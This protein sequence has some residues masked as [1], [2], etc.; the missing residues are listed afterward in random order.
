[1]AKAGFVDPVKVIRAAVTDAASVSSLTSIE[2]VITGLAKDDA[3]ALSPGG[4]GGMHYRRALA[5]MLH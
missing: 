3:L 5:E 4:I 2:A 1:M